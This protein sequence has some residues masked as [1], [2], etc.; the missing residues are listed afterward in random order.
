MRIRTPLLVTAVAATMLAG[1][2]LPALADG[3]GE[4]TPILDGATGG[5]TATTFTLTGGEM[6]VTILPVATLVNGAPGDD[7]VTGTL[8]TVLVSDARGSILGWVVSAASA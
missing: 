5:S 4:P 6:S 8:G 7:S 1:A 3:S 2:A